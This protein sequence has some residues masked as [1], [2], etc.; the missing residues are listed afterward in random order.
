MRRSPILAD[1]IRETEL[2]ALFGGARLVKTLAGKLETCGGT[3]Q[4]QQAAREWAKLFLTPTPG[5]TPS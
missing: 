1:H 4:D 5:N 2:I 3:E